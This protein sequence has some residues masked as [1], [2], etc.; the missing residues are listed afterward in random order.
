MA[1][2]RDGDSSEGGPGARTPNTEEDNG[3]TVYITVLEIPDPTLGKAAAMRGV[4]DN[5][6]GINFEIKEDRVDVVAAGSSVLREMQNAVSEVSPDLGI[7]TG[8]A[9]REREHELKRRDAVLEKVRREGE[10]DGFLKKILF[11]V[12]GQGVNQGRQG[13]IDLPGVLGSSRVWYYLSLRP[14]DESPASLAALPS[15]TSA[16]SAGTVSR[17]LRVWRLPEWANRRNKNQG[18]A[19]SCEPVKCAGPTGLARNVCSTSPCVLAF[20]RRVIE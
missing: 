5:T 15:M 6:Q 19:R 12:E 2:I 13:R 8:L 1:H 16:W 9:G 7:M 3:D 17:Q 14:T 18:L 11:P 20:T 10:D 4:F